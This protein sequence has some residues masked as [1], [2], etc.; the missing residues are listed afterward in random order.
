MVQFELPESGVA[1][2]LVQHCNDFYGDVS[3]RGFTD[4][5]QGSSR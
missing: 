1:L 3:A 5:I 2:K 4:T